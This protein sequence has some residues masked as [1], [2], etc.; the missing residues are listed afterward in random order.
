MPAAIKV[1][2][3][4]KALL[5]FLVPPFGKFPPFF[6]SFPQKLQKTLLPSIAL[7]QYKHSLFIAFILKTYLVHQIPPTCPILCFKLYHFVKVFYDL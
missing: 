1:I 7:P 2:I 4:N 5:C 6:C 3:N